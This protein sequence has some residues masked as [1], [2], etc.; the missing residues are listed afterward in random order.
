MYIEMDGSWSDFDF[1]SSLF[2]FRSFIRVWGKIKF[3]ESSFVIKSGLDHPLG[4][5]SSIQGLD[6]C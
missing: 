5:K 2:L 3:S 1:S 6:S 4:K